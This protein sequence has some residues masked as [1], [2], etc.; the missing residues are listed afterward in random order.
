MTATRKGK[1]LDGSAIVQ[2]V[3]ANN[4][5]RAA[6]CVVRE[7]LPI[8][9][10]VAIKPSPDSV[11]VAVDVARIVPVSDVEAIGLDVD[12][13]GWTVGVSEDWLPSFE[14]NGA[15]VFTAKV[16]QGLGRFSVLGVPPVGI[17]RRK[18][19]C[20]GTRCKWASQSPRVG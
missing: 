20:C 17:P 18:R 8:I 9:V 7:E 13:K 10:P 1:S 12:V 19:P 14:G 6:P 2:G 5:G 3:I 11:E 16:A 15:V 4:D